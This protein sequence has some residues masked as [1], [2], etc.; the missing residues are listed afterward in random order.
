LSAGVW[1]ESRFQSVNESQTAYS[2][3]TN[4]MMIDAAI[5]GAASTHGAVGGR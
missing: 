4:T 1:L 2:S 5:A 3:G